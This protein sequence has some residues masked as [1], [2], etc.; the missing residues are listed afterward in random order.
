[1][2]SHPEWTGPYLGPKPT[3]HIIQWDE[4]KLRAGEGIVPL[5]AGTNKFASQKGI[6]IGRA[7]DIM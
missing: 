5:Q 6:R 7:R 2:Y 1:M 3:G 4:T